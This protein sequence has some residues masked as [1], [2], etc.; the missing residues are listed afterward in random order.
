MDFPNSTS[1]EAFGDRV[2]G[3]LIAT[4]SGGAWKDLLV[5]IYSRFPVQESI[6]VPA[7][8]EPLIVWIL[9]GTALFEERELGGDWLV[10]RVEAGD[11]F[12]T[13]SKTPYEA[14][15]Q[16]I[17]DEPFKTMHLYLGLSIFR[18]A[19]KE[20][21]DLNDVTPQLR[22]ISGQKDQVLSLLLAQLRD[23]LTSDHK[24]SALFVQGIAQSLAVHLIRNYLDTT[25][26]P[27]EQKG[28]LPAFKLRK[29]IDLLEAQLHEEFSLR[30]LAREAGMSD[31][32][33]SRLFKK[34]TGFTPSSYFI[35]LRMAEARR[36]LRETSKSIIEVAIDVGYTNPSHFSQIFRREVGVSPS[37]YRGRK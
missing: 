36:L 32:H 13:T 17:G 19:A 12:L 14:R 8:A 1:P 29:I 34:A 30:R 5:R 2:R 18:K 21:L 37:E 24:T 25:V 10:N 3:T 31:F 11:F 35:R 28:G 33:F 27:R 9:S 22:E 6:I 15:W 23:E 26:G 16:A 20:V 7:V 4:S